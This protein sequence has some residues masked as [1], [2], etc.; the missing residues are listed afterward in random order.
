MDTPSGNFVINIGGGT[1]EAAVIAM[2]D[3]VV[4]GAVR[5]G[6]NKISEAIASHIRRKYNLMV[7][8]Q[9]AVTTLPTSVMNSFGRS[10]IVAASDV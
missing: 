7:G 8:E 4:S 1:S 6:G 3:I 9:T 2:N 5:V 10:D